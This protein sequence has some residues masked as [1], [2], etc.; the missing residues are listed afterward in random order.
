MKWNE[1]LIECQ[2]VDFRKNIYFCKIFEKK[3]YKIFQRFISRH[4]H[5]LLSSRKVSQTS[6]P[7]TRFYGSD[8]FSEE[9]E[10]HGDITTYHALKMNQLSKILL[11]FQGNPKWEWPFLNETDLLLKYSMLMSFVVLIVIFIIQVFNRS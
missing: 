4:I 10:D 2:L 3:N 1:N 7:A 11:Q 6:L 9:F 8:S 5:K